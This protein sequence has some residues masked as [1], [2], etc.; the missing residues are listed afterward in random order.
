MKNHD[1][2]DCDCGAS[3]VADSSHDLGCNGRCTR[4]DAFAYD[5]TDNRQQVA[6]AC[7]PDESSARCTMC[8]WAIT[9]TLDAC[10]DAARSH[11]HAD[12]TIVRDNDGREVPAER[13][14]A[15]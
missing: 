13:D 9:G 3:E 1:V 2:K 10:D 12:A 14:G 11:C 4:C 8:A 15:N 5:C 6:V 7:E